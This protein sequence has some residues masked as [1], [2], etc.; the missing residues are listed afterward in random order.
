MKT[1]GSLSGF[2]VTDIR[3]PISILDI[4]IIWNLDIMDNLDI[5]ILVRIYVLN[6]GETK[7]FELC[8]GIIKKECATFLSTIWG[9]KRGEKTQLSLKI[10]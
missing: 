6:H 1:R 3:K 2:I 4:G 7:S 9:A 8:S 5:Y 10:D